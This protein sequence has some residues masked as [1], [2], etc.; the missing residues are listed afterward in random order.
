MRSKILVGIMVLLI[1]GTV[2]CANMPEI[3]LSPPTV[4]A[5]SGYCPAT[6]GGMVV[7]WYADS[8]VYLA[9]YGLD[10]HIIDNGDTWDIYKADGTVI[11]R[12]LEK[13]RVSYG[14]YKYQPITIELDENLTQIPIYV[15]DLGLETIDGDD[16]PQSE[17]IGKLTAVNTALNR[18]ATVTRKWMGQTYTVQCLVTEWVK[19]MYLSGS[20]QIGDYVLVSFIEEIPNTTEIHVAIV[21]DKVYESW[22]G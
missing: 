5:T 20:L 19:A 22:S 10:I 14:Y 4:G 8:G 6:M 11:W 2:A 13:W 3:D 17:H 18:P 1:G 21:T 15:E 9:S 16:L 12:D 7:F